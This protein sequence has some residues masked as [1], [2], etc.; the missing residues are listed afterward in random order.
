[1]NLDGEEM[2]KYKGNGVWRRNFMELDRESFGA[3]FGFH[4]LK[5]NS[6]EKLGIAV[7]ESR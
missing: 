2:R 4:D 6:G 3:V 1:M 7:G 5:G